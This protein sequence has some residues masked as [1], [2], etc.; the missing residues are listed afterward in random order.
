MHATAAERMFTA[1][2]ASCRRDKDA[3]NIDGDKSVQWNVG[4]DLGH[5]ADVVRFNRVT[6]TR[7]STVDMY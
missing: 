3:W 6:I 1:K 2:K 4:V 5:L 7:M